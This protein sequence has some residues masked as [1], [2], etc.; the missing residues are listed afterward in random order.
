VN[1]VRRRL[2]PPRRDIPRRAGGFL[3]RVRPAD[4]DV[5]KQPVI[6]FRQLATA[7][8]RL[9]ATAQPIKP[10]AAPDGDDPGCRGGKEAAR[11]HGAIL[12]I[13]PEREGSHWQ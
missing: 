8:D 1:D 7:P 9:N 11:G 13:A 10:S 12:L 3:Q 2:S 5:G 4:A 6:Q